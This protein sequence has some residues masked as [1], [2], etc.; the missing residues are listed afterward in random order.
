MRAKP[1]GSQALD[2]GWKSVQRRFEIIYEAV[3]DILSSRADPAERL[4][5]LEKTLVRLTGFRTGPPP[6]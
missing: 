6:N 4:S 5:Q 1:V 2:C 3:H